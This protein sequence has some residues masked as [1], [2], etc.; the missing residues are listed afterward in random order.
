[1]HYT[2]LILNVILD[3]NQ[4]YIYIRFPMWES[5]VHSTQTY[6]IKPLMQVNC[7]NPWMNRVVGGWEVRGYWM[8]G[9]LHSGQVISSLQAQRDK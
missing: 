9:E 7:I 3:F 4:H 5:V 2:L 1:M 6:A 8:S